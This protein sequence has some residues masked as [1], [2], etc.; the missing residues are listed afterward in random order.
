MKS[1][2]PI[3]L[4]SMLAALLCL[5][6]IAVLAHHF[7]GLPHY[8]YF[9]NY[10]EIP[11][12]EFLG[13]VGD[14]EVSLVVYDF[15]GI[16]RGKVDDPDMVRLFLVIF[17]LRNNDIYGGPLTLEV[18]DKGE[19]V[20]SERHKSSELENLYSMHQELPDTGDYSLR[21]TLHSV[22]DLQCVI[23]FQLSSQKI[24]WGKW[25]AAVLLLL[26]I[27]AAI[28]ARKARVTMDR[29]EEAGRRKEKLE[30]SS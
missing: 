3:R 7:K 29:K 27:V 5:L 14:Y 21:L 24:H 10:P 12:E 18:L 13:Q 26:I 6:P 2:L 8:N 9:E 25:V 20:H 28:G 22:D 15:Q 17:N 19:V 30:E 4:L 23:P 1:H 11:E 16:Q